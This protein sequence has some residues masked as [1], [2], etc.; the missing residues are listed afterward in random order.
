MN[1]K[2]ILSVVAIFVGMM[3]YIPYLRDVVKG[4]TKPHT[5]SWLVWGILTVIVFI[6]QLIDQGGFGTWVTGFT[7][8]AVLII[9]IFGIFKGEKNITKGD[10]ASL[11]AALFTIVIWILT[12]EPLIAIILVTIIDILA[13]YPT[14]RKTILKPHE[15]T[16]TLYLLSGIKWILAILALQ[17]Y[18]FVTLLY[19]VYLVL[20]NGLFVTLL[21]V[22]RKKQPMSLS[23]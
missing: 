19:P 6:G 4:K 11:L 3:S 12:S 15:E 5:F 8:C 7:A 9:F 10:W 22:Y 1:F 17:N 13:F 23:L 14:I 21:L 2:I 18:S 16:L 20:I